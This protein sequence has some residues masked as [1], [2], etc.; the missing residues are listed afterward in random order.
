MNASN[1]RAAER[2]PVFEKTVKSGIFKGRHHRHLQK[3]MSHE[4]PFFYFFMNF[5]EQKISHAPRAQQDLNI[6]GT[7]QSSVLYL[8]HF[9]SPYSHTNRHTKNLTKI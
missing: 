3:R 7:L 8:I 6:V 2:I 1:R 4:F 5:T 9:F